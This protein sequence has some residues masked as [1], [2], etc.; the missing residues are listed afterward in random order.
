MIGRATL[1]IGAVIIWVGLIAVAISGWR[2]RA[3]KA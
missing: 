2:K 1:G 3:G